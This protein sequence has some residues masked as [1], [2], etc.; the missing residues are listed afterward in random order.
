MVQFSDQVV[1][2]NVIWLFEDCVEVSSGLIH[3]LI[4]SMQCEMSSHDAIFVH[5]EGHTDWNVVSQ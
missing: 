3:Y 4:D 1:M 5:D 2:L